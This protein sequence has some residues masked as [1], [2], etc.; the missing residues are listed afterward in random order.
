[1]YD[2][3]TGKPKGFGFCEFADEATAH[4]AIRNLNKQD[5]GGRQ[6]RVDYADRGAAAQDT[7]RVAAPQAVPA[8]PVR[9][10]PRALN[11]VA[12]TIAQLEPH[13]LWDLMAQM[14]VRALPRAS[15]AFS[16]DPCMCACV[17]PRCGTCRS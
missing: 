16:I 12:N 10:D 15:T 8:Q 4:S 17:L 13:E 9:E 5:V 7:A 2:R 1:M 14:K 11:A 3:D 6:L